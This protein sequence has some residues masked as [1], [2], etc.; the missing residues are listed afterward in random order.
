M[1][2]ATPRPNGQH[3]A[4]HVRPLDSVLAALDEAECNACKHALHVLKA[5]LETTVP[6]E[7]TIPV[8]LVILE[9]SR[10]GS[11]FFRVARCPYCG[12]QHQHGVP[13]S[14]QPGDAPGHRVADCMMAK[15]PG[16]GYELQ[17][18]PGGRS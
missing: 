8:A 4:D 13:A 6:I 14:W 17:L 2:S 9:T 15:R 1:A 10:R 11:R 7:P 3:P 16:A 18:A 12:K 5:H